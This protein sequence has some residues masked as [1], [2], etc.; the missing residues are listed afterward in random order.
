MPSTQVSPTPAAL[1]CVAL[2]GIVALMVILLDAFTKWLII[3]E[4][5]PGADRF[6]VS[7]IAETVELRYAT[8]GGIAFGLLSGSST[9]AGVLAGAIIIPLVVVLLLN[10]R[11]G[12]DWALGAG[13]VLGGA[14]GNLLDR[15]GDATVTDFISIGPWPSFN[16]ADAAISVGAVILIACSFRSRNE[17]SETP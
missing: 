14:A 11:R 9:I 3:R 13:L 8:N 15:I 12:A 2:A 4:L 1:R 17:S 16:L 10:A 6:S 5:G 7:I